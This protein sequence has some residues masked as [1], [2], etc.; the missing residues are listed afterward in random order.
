MA[1]CPRNIWQIA[2]VPV[3]SPQAPRRL[4]G[5]SFHHGYVL[6]TGHRALPFGDR[7]TALPIS[8]LWADRPGTANT[9][10]SPAT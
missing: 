8:N 4:A 3:S 5:T 1:D 10:T 6:Y 9:M 2:H 7:L